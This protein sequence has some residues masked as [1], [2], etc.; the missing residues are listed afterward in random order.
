MEVRKS[1]FK[2]LGVLGAIDAYVYRKINQKL[3]GAMS[4][5][6]EIKEFEFIT[7]MHIT[8]HLT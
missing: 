4:E 2:L 5:E 8:K 3:K 6:E 1:L 7:E